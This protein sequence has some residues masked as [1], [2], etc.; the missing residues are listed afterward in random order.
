VGSGPL[1]LPL[2][3]LKQLTQ[4]CS[5]TPQKTGIIT[6]TIVTTSEVTCFAKSPAM[7]CTVPLHDL[8]Q[9]P[10][11]EVQDQGKIGHAA[12]AKSHR[13]LRFMLLLALT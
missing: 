3:H 4:Q 2:K 5:V 8:L 7:Q 10:Y 1:D 12:K 9:W 13:N 6:Y 11:L